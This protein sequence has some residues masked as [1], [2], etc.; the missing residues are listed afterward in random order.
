MTVQTKRSLLTDP[1]PQSAS[2]QARVSLTP[3][4]SL[5]AEVPLT[6]SA[7]K[8]GGRPRKTAALQ[9]QLQAPHLVGALCWVAPPPSP[10]FS[11]ASESGIFDDDLPPRVTARNSSLKWLRG[12][13]R[14]PENKAGHFPA[15]HS[16]SG[17]NN[18]DRSHKKKAAAKA[19]RSPHLL[20]VSDDGDS[21]T[22]PLFSLYHST[23]LIV[24]CSETLDKNLSERH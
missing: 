2:P 5:L 18:S 1:C 15:L 3:I 22:R 12:A 24:S 13:T 17:E 8:S 11:S 7:L 4:P 10:H 20:C 14:R 21:G 16:F 9:P 23:V 6:P 19:H